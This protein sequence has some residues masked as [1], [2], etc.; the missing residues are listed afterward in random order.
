[1]VPQSESPDVC[2]I[3]NI[4]LKCHLDAHRRHFLVRDLHAK[5]SQEP[6]PMSGVYER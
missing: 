5:E 3:L 2:L 6:L 1:M 4:S